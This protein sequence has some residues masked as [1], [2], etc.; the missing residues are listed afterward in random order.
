MTGKVY[1]VGAGPGDP[2][3]LTVRA[4]RLIRAADELICDH[5]LPS[6]FLEDLGVS[7]LDK[8]VHWIEQGPDSERQDRINELM[9]DAA[10][11]GKTVLRLKGG[12]PFVFGRGGEEAKFLCDNKIPWSVV[13]GLSVCTA[14]PSITEHPLTHRAKGRSF[15]VATA[16]CEGGVANTA[17][18]K[19]DSLVI[20]M[21]VSI[22]DDVVE[23][24]LREGWKS[25]TPIALLE[26]VSQP[27]ERRVR[28]TL[29]DAVASAKDAHV[30]APAV[31][32]VGQAADTHSWADS[33]REILFTGSDASCFTTLGRVIHWPAQVLERNEEA[34]ES[35]A[36]IA[37]ELDNAGYDMVVFAGRSSVSSFFASLFRAG[38]DARALAGTCLVAHG[39][40]T[41]TQLLEYGTKADAVIGHD[42]VDEPLP[43]QESSNPSVLL[44]S[45]THIGSSLEELLRSLDSKITRLELHKLVPNPELGRSLPEHDVIY[46]VSPGGVRC[47]HEA[48]GM[49]AFKKE[50]WCMGKA[51]L[52]ELASLDVQAS[53][54][55][56]W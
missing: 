17:F 12:D 8:V 56:P 23:S 30:T 36:S 47:Y 38:K 24:L 3:L 2:E 39:I 1:I 9:L 54:V 27:W 52:S 28:S 33:R 22:L 50:V 14:G 34:E 35:A 29:A 44:I 13:P 46:F 7:P 55:Q 25:D 37:N 48:Y 15:A 53:I 18:P 41:A 42:E 32:L 31:F 40:G 5:L 19:A 10:R 49:D 11:R 21:G 20:L 43:F 51:T 6:S 4:L 16:R 26:R 45:G